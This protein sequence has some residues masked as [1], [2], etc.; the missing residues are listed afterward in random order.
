MKEI[1]LNELKT[2]IQPGKKHPVIINTLPQDAFLKDHIPG[3]INIPEN[4]LDQYAPKLF[5]KHDWIVVYCSGPS[6][7]VSHKAAEKLQKLGFT[8]VYRYKGG[9]EDWKNSS[10]YTCHETFTGEG[11]KT[12][13]A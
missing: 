12:K 4:Q 6:C 7:Q 3:S 2:M 11:R 13:A 8:N 10:D 1:T 5:A 9:V